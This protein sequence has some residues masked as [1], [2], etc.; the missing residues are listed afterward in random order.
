[1]ERNRN[2]KYSQQRNELALKL[3]R[4]LYRG[5]DGKELSL[6]GRRKTDDMEN[7]SLTYGEIVPQSFLQIL[8]SLTPSTSSVPSSA[9]PLSSSPSP[10]SPPSSCGKVFVDLGCGVGVAVLTA[11]LSSCHFTTVWGIE[12]LP[13]LADAA[14]LV[15]EMLSNYLTQSHIHSPEQLKREEASPSVK[16]LTSS[17]SDLNQAIENIF[18][19]TT[20]SHLSIESLVDQIVKRVGHKEYKKMLK[21]SKSFKKFLSLYP[22]RYLLEG[23]EVCLVQSVE[24]SFNEL[25]L[26]QDETFDETSDSCPDVSSETLE[27]RRQIRPEAI[28]SLLRT[29][30]GRTLCQEGNLPEIRFDCDDIFRVNWWDSGD[31]VYC[32]SLL[33]SD[34]MMARL[35]ELVW[36]MKPDSYFISL[37]SFPS[38]IQIQQGDVIH[39]EDAEERFIGRELRLVSDSFYRMSWQMARVYIYQI[40][41]KIEREE[42]RK[43]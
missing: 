12:L 36:R 16:P 18:H 6:Q 27:S 3:V 31:I 13:E 39:Q 40:G 24:Y 19:A 34:E 25:Q 22:S 38:Q 32:A 30:T 26:P 43:S 5:I 9:T 1:M 41:P 11:A 4:E 15:P 37:K 29:P 17:H 14:K 8:F 42:D 35:L 10:P 33:F 21:G 23:E 2:R 20:E 7:L 28:L